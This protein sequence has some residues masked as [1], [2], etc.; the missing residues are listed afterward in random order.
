[1]GPFERSQ[2]VVWL[3]ALFALG[4]ELL[5][6]FTTV[7]PGAPLVPQW[8]QFALFPLVFVVHFRTIFLLRGRSTKEVFASIPRLR[9]FTFGALVVVVWGIGLYSILHIGG[10]PEQRGDYYFLND[11]GSMIPVTRAAFRHALVLQTRIF[12]LVPSMFFAIAV[13]LHSRP[14]TSRSPTPVLSR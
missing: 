2:R 8:P 7:L 6:A 4:A 9:R 13:L 12:T 5:I 3:V 10:Q 1:V 11:H 14:T